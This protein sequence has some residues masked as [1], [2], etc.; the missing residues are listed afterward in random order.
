MTPRERQLQSLLFQCPDKVTLAP[1]GPR[2][3]TR[4]VWHKQGLPEGVHYMKA[5][6]EILGI[7]PDVQRPQPDLGVDF[8]MIPQFEE[9]VLEHKDGH[10][11]VQDWMGAI[12]EISDEFDYTYIRSA[13]DFVTRKWH[14]FPVQ[15]RADW[16]QMVWRYDVDTP[17]RFPDDFD[18]RCQKLQDRD[19]FLR[20]HFNGPFWQLREW[21]GLENLCVMMI[22]DSDFVR[23]MIHH[24]TAFTSQ[25]L[26]RILQHI[27]PDQVGFSED[28]AY[29]AHSMISPAMVRAFLVPSYDQWISQ[30]KAADV[31][32]IFMDS[33]GQIEELIPIWIEAGI[34]CCG[35][36]EVAAGNDIVAFRERFGK[37]MAYTG[38]VDKRAIA[39]G[40][41]IMKAEVMRTVPPLL[42]AG[43]VI[44]GCDHGVPPDISW[45]NFVAYTRLLAQLTGW[46]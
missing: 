39:A 44:P 26:N 21:V 12:T 37:K 8:K 27:T 15:T 43:G 14:K 17:G 10:Y 7:E 24:W 3:S 2:E 13:K 40:G 1:G 36:I 5:L 29:K 34:N 6:Y 42:K 28:M 22:E 31:P 4:A 38:C 35:P 45:P 25:I 41:D 18:E 19:G 9:K 32:V 16:D 33:D 46:I 11:I 30:M 23:E 20:V